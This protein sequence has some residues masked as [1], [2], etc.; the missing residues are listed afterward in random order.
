MVCLLRR[1]TMA[2]RRRP[3]PSLEMQ[4]RTRIERHFDETEQDLPDYSGKL[5]PVTS[6]LSTK[7]KLYSALSYLGLK[8]P[9][10]RT[11]TA[12]DTVWLLDNTAYRNS[13]TG[14]WEAEFVTAV[15]SQHSSVL[16]DA[17]GDIATKLGMAEHDPAY[18]TLE[19]RLRPFVQDIKPGTK[20][21]ALYRG[22]LP[23]KLGPGS[24]NGI[25]SQVKT[26]PGGTDGEV[27]PT[28]AD[29]P[30]GANG[31]LEMRSFCAEPEGWG[32]ISGIVA[33]PDPGA[34][35]GRT[36]VVLTRAQISTIPS[37]SRKRVIPSASCKLPS[38]ILRSPRRVCRSYTNTFIPS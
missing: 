4:K 22:K 24:Y 6:T 10:S 21:K 25:S 7:D 36:V 14:R 31:L 35:L 29:V 8:N 23:L 28:F 30:K 26:L 2:L 1:I 18:A 33:F 27:V 5:T 15:F 37:R 12:N 20:V 13:Q 11:V 38:S 32:L 3:T 17:V 9:I 16:V 34:T 19:D